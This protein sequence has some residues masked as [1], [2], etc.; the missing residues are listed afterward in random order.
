MSGYAVIISPQAWDALMKLPDR[1]AQ[2]IFHAIENLE[3][4]PR[5]SGMKKLVGVDE[6]GAYRIRIGVYR[7][8]YDIEDDVLTVLIVRVAKRGEIYKKRR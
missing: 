4:E 8:V 2:R 1:D 5:P 6:A 3:S 7:V